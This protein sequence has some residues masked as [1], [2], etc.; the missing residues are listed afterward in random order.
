MDP[1]SPEGVALVSLSSGHF[2][3]IVEYGTT[4][5]EG[6]YLAIRFGRS[7]EPEQVLE[8]LLEAADLTTENLLWTELDALR[9]D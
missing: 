9:E 1:E 6:L 8:E 4:D 3:E 5:I 2:V 7:S